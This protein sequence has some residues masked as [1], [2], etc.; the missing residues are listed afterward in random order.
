MNRYNPLLALL[1][2][3]VLALAPD[4]NSDDSK[5]LS[6]EIAV[7][8]FN[9][10]PAIYGFK[11]RDV[12]HFQLELPQPPPPI[13]I[14]GVRL[15]LPIGPVRIDYGQPIPAGSTGPIPAGSTGRFNLNGDFPGPGYREQRARFLNK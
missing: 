14:T 3:F 15:D 2:G 1:V 13:A 7:P 9:L 11:Y 10:N 5:P 8:V 4:A 6:A 12:T